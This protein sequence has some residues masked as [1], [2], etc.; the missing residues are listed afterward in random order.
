MKLYSQDGS[1]LMQVESLERD[2]SDLV[3]KGKVFGSMPMSARLK[4]EEARKGLKLLNVR[5]IGFLLTLLF[6]R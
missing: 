3:I 4:P 6:R 1:E 5:M 2:G